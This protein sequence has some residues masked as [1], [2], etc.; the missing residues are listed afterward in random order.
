MTL[1]N[2]CRLQTSKTI[3]GHC[4][5]IIPPIGDRLI[6]RTMCRILS[7]NVMSRLPQTEPIFSKLTRL[8]MM[9]V[10]TGQMPIRLPTF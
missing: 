10:Q 3:L 2:P 4:L 7:G 6:N 1:N 9:V 5:A 8:F